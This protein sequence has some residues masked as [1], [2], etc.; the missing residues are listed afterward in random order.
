[1]AAWREEN[2]FVFEAGNLVGCLHAKESVHMHL[3]EEL[4]NLSGRL[5][6]LDRVS[7]RDG[8]GK[9]QESRLVADHP[10]IQGNACVLPLTI[11]SKVGLSGAMRL[12]VETG[13]I[14]AEIRVQ[15]VAPVS[16]LSLVVSNRWRADVQFPREMGK[17]KSGRLDRRECSVSLLP[18]DKGRALLMFAD[19]GEGGTAERTPVSEKTDFAQVA[20]SFFRQ[21][22]EKGVILVGRIALFDWRSEGQFTPIDQLYDQWFER[23]TFL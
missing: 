15:T 4:A 17:H 12:L 2:G 11:E 13:G 5:F 21:S 6:S 14:S 22:L 10:Y 9:S 16:E 7:Y 18:R 19:V 23:D 3:G 20:Y 1:M 8:Q